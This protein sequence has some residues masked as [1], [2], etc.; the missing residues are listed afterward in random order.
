VG[1]ILAVLAATAL[2]V[3]TI[4]AGVL[5]QNDPVGELQEGCPPDWWGIGGPG[6]NSNHACVYAE[7]EA[8]SFEALTDMLT[9]DVDTEEC[10][11]DFGGRI[12]YSGNNTLGLCYRVVYDLPSRPWVFVGIQTQACELPDEDGEDPVIFVADGAVA[13]CVVP[14][15]DPD[16]DLPDVDVSTEPCEP[17]TAD[18]EVRFAEGGAR[19]CLD[20]SFYGVGNPQLTYVIDIAGEGLDMVPGYVPTP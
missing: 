20:V 11:D 17:Q 10:P 18:P 5:A 13:F 15:I 12:A 6:S 16:G 7:A 14:V 9:T 2:L 3:T 19:V 8:P 4:P 1:R